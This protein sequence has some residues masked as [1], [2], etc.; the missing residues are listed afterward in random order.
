MRRTSMSKLE[1]KLVDMYESL[2]LNI[3]EHDSL[4]LPISW[5]IFPLPLNSTFEILMNGRKKDIFKK[6]HIF[7]NE[8]SKYIKSYRYDFEI[9]KSDK[10]YINITLILCMTFIVVTSVLTIVYFSLTSLQGILFTIIIGFPAIYVFLVGIIRRRRR[11]NGEKHDPDL[12]KIVQ[13]LID[14]GVKII[15]E[16]KLDPQDYPIKI[17]HND[18]D[19]L[20]YEKQEDNSYLG[21]FKK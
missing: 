6:D 10:M 11:T 4:R 15:N 2:R 5:G 14:Y 17:K 16:N 7:Y 3:M 8:I 13:M 18:Y 19:D 12:K 9:S 20:R 1:I 21:Y